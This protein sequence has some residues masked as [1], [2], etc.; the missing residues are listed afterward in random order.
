MGSQGTG[1]SLARALVLDAGALIALEKGDQN[2]AGLIETGFD[3]GVPI[4]VPASV[5]AQVWRGDARAASVN[6]TVAAAAVDPLNEERSKEVGVRLGRRGGD[7]VA[8]A[9]VVCCAVEH[10]ATVATSDPDDIR[11]LAGSDERLVLIEI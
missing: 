11:A 5:L 10:R 9:H 8:D 1:K 3:L 7:D 4:I 6:R 2:T